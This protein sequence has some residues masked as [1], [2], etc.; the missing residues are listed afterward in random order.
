[1]AKVPEIMGSMAEDSP[2][3]TAAALGGGGDFCVVCVCL[4]PMGDSIDECFS[5]GGRDVAS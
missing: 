3:I 5:L 2:H 4:L 1:L